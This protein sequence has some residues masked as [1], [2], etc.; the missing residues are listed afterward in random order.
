MDG[1]DRGRV[2]AHQHEN[3]HTVSFS[4]AGSLLFSTNSLFVLQGEFQAKKL[5]SD[6]HLKGSERK[7]TI[8]TERVQFAWGEIPPPPPQAQHHI[9][10]LRIMKTL[11][12][13]CLCNIKPPVLYFQTGFP[14]IFLPTP[15]S[16]PWLS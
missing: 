6:Q 12:L 14:S 3:H 1:C 13:F 8:P 4:S 7:S 10:G 5:F 2:W 15:S 11:Y 16:G 9:Y